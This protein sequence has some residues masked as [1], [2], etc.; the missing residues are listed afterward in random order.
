MQWPMLAWG[1]QAGGESKSEIDVWSMP[2]AR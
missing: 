2:D 1:T